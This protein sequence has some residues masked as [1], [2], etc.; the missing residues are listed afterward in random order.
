MCPV[1]AVQTG[2][3]ILGDPCYIEPE[4]EGLALVR[5]QSQAE[6][7]ELVFRAALRNI[8]VAARRVVEHERP[9]APGAAD[10][11][12]EIRAVALE[13]EPPADVARRLA[14]VV[15]A[16]AVRPAHTE[17]LAGDEQ[18]F[19]LLRT[20]S[21]PKTC[22]S[23]AS[24]SV[25]AGRTACAATTSAR[26]RATSAGGSRSRATARISDRGS[27]APGA[28]GRSCSTTR[29]AATTM[30]RSA[31]RKTSS[32]ASAWDC[33]RTRASPSRSGSMWHGSPRM[34]APV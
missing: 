34:Q 19:G 23:P 10:P 28:R 9:R 25:W 15:A 21:R 2:A 5:A 14:L 24:N 8:V 12:S 32:G 3:C 6:A 1:F 27:A 30:F 16:H 22:S 4:R 18:V 33:A 29:R 11:R 13:R 31:A 20:P 17:L 7:P 26:R